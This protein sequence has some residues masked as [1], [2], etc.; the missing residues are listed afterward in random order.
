MNPAY[1]LPD[2]LRT[3]LVT[4]FCGSAVG[5]TSARVGAYYA[6]GG[7]R[8]WAVLHEAGFT[9]RQLRPDEYPLVS[10]YG[11]GLT[12]LAKYEFGNDADLSTE[13]YQSNALRKKIERYR[14]RFLAFTAKAPARVF[15]REQFGVALAAG[16]DGY[17]LQPHAIAGTRLWVLPS[18]SGRAKTFWQPQP[19]QE[20]AARHRAERERRAGT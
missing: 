9:D 7:N 13:A 11:L 20:L 17:G 12:D 19:W 3:G 16:P 14:P 18:T 2:V 15:L 6:R 4:V 5:F 8:F 1:V 10:G